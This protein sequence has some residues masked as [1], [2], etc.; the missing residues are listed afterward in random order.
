MKI[1]AMLRGMCAGLVL[2]AAGP[3]IADVGEA[4]VMPE[5]MI[6]EVAACMAE[7]GSDC[8]TQEG[9]PE[10]AAEFSKVL[11]EM[12][13][14]G[15]PGFLVDFTEVGPVDVGQV[16]LPRLST[17]ETHLVLLNGVRDAVLAVEVAFTPEP[18]ATPGTRAILSAHPD[19]VEQSRLRLTGYR[20]MPG[21]AQRFVLGDSV[22]E[23]CAG[24]EDVGLSL[25]YLD[26][27]LGALIRVERPGWLPP[28]PPADVLVDLIERADI[29]V[30]Q[31]RLKTLGYDAGPVDGVAGQRTL[32]AL[33]DLKD[34][35]CLPRDRK[36]VTVVDLL[37]A[38]DAVPEAPP[39]AQDIFRRPDPEPGPIT[40]P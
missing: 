13:V 2:G 22:S 11:A 9:V 3:A 36:I 23:G 25:T 4:E 6:A 17:V 18:P 37:A 20:V 26:F 21:G 32:R 33:Y 12:T 35:H 16:I 19:A 7:G 24:C 29:R 39:C 40:I 5:A 30:V 28:E 31:A 1:E 10:G 38:T 8:L 34:E 14:L 27:V 15:L